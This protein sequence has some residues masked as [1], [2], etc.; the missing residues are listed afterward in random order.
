MGNGVVGG[1]GNH[2]RQIPDGA[3]DITGGKAQCCPAAARFS[4]V[5][6]R[7]DGAVQ[8]G[9]GA[10]DVAGP[11]ADGGAQSQGGA[12]AGPQIE[13]AVDILQGARGIAGRIARIG[14]VE[15][16]RGPG[17]G[18]YASPLYHRAARHQRRGVHPFFGKGPAGLD[19]C[20]G[21]LVKRQ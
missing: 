17:G 6:A 14:A 9:A 3:F 13:R 20:P 7:S 4:A 19:A 18:P 10:P 5:L 21:G 15:E 8:I 16:R 11:H 2:R 1:G 12:E